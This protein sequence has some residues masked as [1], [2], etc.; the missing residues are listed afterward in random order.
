[1]CNI[2]K[3]KLMLLIIDLEN[4]KVEEVE[5]PHG[6]NFNDDE[7]TRGDVHSTV[8]LNKETHDHTPTRSDLAVEDTRT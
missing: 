8:K 4:K 2:I 3:I 1:M 7:D 6:S 5:N